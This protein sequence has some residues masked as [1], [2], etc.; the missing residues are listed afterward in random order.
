[1]RGGIAVV[2]AES[3]YVMSRIVTKCFALMASALLCAQQAVLLMAQAQQMGTSAG[4]DMEP[5][6]P[7]IPFDVRDPFLDDEIRA[8]DGAWLSGYSILHDAIV[9]RKVPQG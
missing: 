4:S 7:T 6:L 3:E 9:R 1:M 2:R 5:S 8:S